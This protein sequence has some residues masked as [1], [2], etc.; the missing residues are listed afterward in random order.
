MP[1]GLARSGSGPAGPKCTSKA[2]RTY[3]IYKFSDMNRLEGGCPG[4]LFEVAPG[5]PG[6]S[7]NQRLPEH[8]QSINFRPWIVGRGIVHG[9]CLGCFR[10]G[11]D[12]KGVGQALGQYYLGEVLPQK[13][14]IKC[15]ISKGLFPS[16]LP[17][18]KYFM[19]GRSTSLPGST[20]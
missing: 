17:P 1:R 14:P 19:F 10:A 16:V 15:P 12:R 5:R 6:P 2:A 13:L 8:I 9:A 4:Y 20:S 18:R 3:T 11:R 7:A